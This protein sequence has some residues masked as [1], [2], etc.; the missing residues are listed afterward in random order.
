MNGHNERE[1]IE[2]GYWTAKFL[3]DMSK[4]IHKGI[5]P[6]NCVFIDFLRDNGFAEN[7][8]FVLDN[9]ATILMTAYILLVYPREL[10]EQFDYAILPVDLQQ[11]FTFTIPAPPTTLDN[12]HFITRMRH[13]I[14]H[15]NIE[16]ILGEDASFRFWNVPTNQ[17]FSDRNL[18]VAVS[19]QNFVEFL[20]RLGKIFIDYIRNN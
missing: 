13:A 11:S 12:K 5:K 18:D 3:F 20:S 4:K 19:K 15:A 6:E 7:T 9:Q 1:I 2:W 10:L 8:T 16:L 14:A 17:N